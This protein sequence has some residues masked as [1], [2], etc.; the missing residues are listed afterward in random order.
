MDSAAAGLR[1]SAPEFPDPEPGE[2]AI[3]ETS[4]FIYQIN[5]NSLRLRSPEIEPDKDRDRIF[6]VGDSFVF[7]LG[8]KEEDTF[9]RQ[10]E[11]LLRK[12]HGD[13][14]DVLNL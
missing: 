5:I 11:A 2:T 3:H 4:E 1:D 8:V 6:F 10:T 7:G 9:T 12:E 14:L 13:N